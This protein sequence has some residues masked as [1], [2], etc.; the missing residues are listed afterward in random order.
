MFTANIESLLVRMGDDLAS[1]DEDWIADVKVSDNDEASDNG[2]DSDTSPVNNKSLGKRKIVE[3]VTD[4]DGDEDIKP[5]QSKKKKKR[6]SRDKLLL[7]AGRSIEEQSPQEQA[8][9]LSTALQ[10]YTLMDLS[11]SSNSTRELSIQP[12]HFTTSAK[13]S[14]LE[15]MKDALSSFKKLKKWKTVG[16][17][18]VVVICMSARRAVAIL[19]ELSS[20]KVRVAK[21]FPKN[22]SVNEQK[23]QLAS[24]AFGL[25]VATPHRLLAL[26]DKKDDQDTALNFGKTQLVILDS[27][28]SNKQFTVA[29]L[30]DTAPHCMALL[31]EHLL[32][33]LQ[34]RKDIKL[35]FF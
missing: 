27:T 26:L 32:P 2:N 11:S 18:C 5:K 21:L 16:S 33:E 23:L 10:H 22:G 20:L 15:R 30:P 17:P 13:A 7:Q 12:D 24:H 14:L 1:D 28:R 3:T 31:R 6:Q 25:A 19:K 8:A 4:D 35:A 34:Q 29:T 9:F